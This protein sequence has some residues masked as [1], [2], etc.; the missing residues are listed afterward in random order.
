MFGSRKLRDG[1]PFWDSWIC[2]HTR[3][4]ADAEA[5]AVYMGSFFTRTN[6]TLN[7][8]KWTDVMRGF[9]NST[10]GQDGRRPIVRY[11][12]AY[13]HGLFLCCRGRVQAT[14]GMQ[15]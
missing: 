9:N 11:D 12:S 10:P 1:R 8:L 2:F 4:Y 6:G 7:A 3:L 13:V 15:R 5:P 14:S